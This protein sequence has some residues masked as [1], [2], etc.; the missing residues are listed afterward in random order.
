MGLMCC[1]WTP[2]FNPVE[3]AP[4]DWASVKEYRKKLLELGE[5]RMHFGIHRRRSCYL[6]PGTST[7]G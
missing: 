5:N 3:L 7:N 4:N 2:P 1:W 6:G